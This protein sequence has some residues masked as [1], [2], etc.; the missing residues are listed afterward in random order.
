MTLTTI[1]LNNLYLYNIQ[2]YQIALE[3]GNEAY[4]VAMELLGTYDLPRLIQAIN[5]G[6]ANK[7][8]EE[9]LTKKGLQDTVYIKVESDDVVIAT[10]NLK[11]KN[12]ALCCLTFLLEKKLVIEVWVGERF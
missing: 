2:D 9:F 8:L 4:V 11:L 10:K 5:N 1:I 12:K 7:M 3:N 6:E